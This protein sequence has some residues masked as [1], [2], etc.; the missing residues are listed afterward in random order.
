M[1]TST[2]TQGHTGTHQA[3]GSQ[4]QPGTAHGQTGGSYGQGGRQM[5]GQHSQ[6]QQGQQGESRPEHTEG[7]VARGIES[8]TAKLPSDLFLWAAL[9]SI[10]CSLMLQM[11]D[12]KH[13]AIF[14]GQWAPTF[15]ILG[16]YNKLVKVAGSDP[17]PRTGH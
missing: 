14:V 8:Q 3:G 16:L 4:G 15:L 17:V 7:M 1:Q 2:T 10:G 11:S 5:S 13:D 12:R 9:G 6:G